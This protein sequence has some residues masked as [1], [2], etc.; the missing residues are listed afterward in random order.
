LKFLFQFILLESGYRWLSADDFSRT[1]ISYEWIKEPKI[2]S[3]VWLSPHFWLNGLF[4]FFIKDIMIAAGLVSVIFSAISLYYFYKVVELSFNK[5]IAIISSVIFCVFPFQAWLSMSGL[6][7]STYFCFVIAGIY[8]FIKWYQDNLS[9]NLILSA[10]MLAFSNGFR[11]EGWLFS[12][13]LIILTLL[14]SFFP[15]RKSVYE[16]F[17]SEETITNKFNY[18]IIARNFLISCISVTTIIWWLLQNYFDTGDALFFMS[19]TAKIYEQFNNAGFLQKFVQYPTFIFYIAPLTTVFSFKVIY[20]NIKSKGLSAEKL[21]VIFNLIQLLMLMAQGLIGTG[22]TNMISRYIVINAILLIPL[23]VKQALELRKLFTSLA[24][25]S[26]IIVNVIWC[27]YFPQPY[28]EDTFEVGYLLK[29]L[30]EN[31]SITENEKVFFEEDPG[32]LDIWAIKSLSNH[33]D[34]IVQGIFPLAKQQ[35]KGKKKKNKLTDEELNILEIKNYLEKNNINTAIVRSD[36]YTDK[37]KKLSLRNEQIGDYQIFYLKEQ[38]SNINDSSVS[39]FASKINSPKDNP[40]LINFGQIIGLLN[41]AIDNTNFGLNPQTVTLEWT[42]ADKGMLDSIDF[43]EFEFDR[44]KALIKIVNPDNDSSVY[45]IS[46]RIFSERN[47]E[48]IIENNYIKNII[49]L[50]PFALLM[51]SRKYG[52][53]PFDGGIYNL[54]LSVLDSKT[55]NELLLYRGSE[56]YKRERTVMKDTLITTSQNLELKVDTNKSKQKFAITQVDSVNYSMPL[57]SIIAMFPDS[58]YNKIAAKKS[59]FVRI[60]LTHSLQYIFSQRYQADHVLNW[61]FTYF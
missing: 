3:G 37:L 12:F 6:P 25:A 50:K 47:I 16:E 23:A 19:E 59:E 56:A 27:F 15:K 60:T 35:E 13:T 7:E 43:E 22:G 14:V 8:Y 46:S 20:E 1:V 33:P 30:I 4:M 39:S 31:K 34:K 48:N 52:K 5:Q 42:A 21:F 51:Y 18:K 40:N 45:T 2:Y 44:Y 32:Y 29:G 10:V 41:F 57:A 58:D 9:R 55:N 17:P 54:E 49:V 28:R 26:F 61:V 11:Y 38:T 53:S 36:G 24:L